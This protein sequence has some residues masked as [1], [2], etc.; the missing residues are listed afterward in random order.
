MN[1]FCCIRL[2]TGVKVIAVLTAVSKFWIIA[3]NCWQV[4]WLLFLLFF[5]FKVWALFSFSVRLLDTYT[6]DP[7][8]RGD[9][10]EEN[11][12]QLY[13]SSETSLEEEDDWEQKTD[14]EKCKNSFA[15]FNVKRFHSSDLLSLIVL[16]EVTHLIIMGYVILGSY[17]LVLSYI[18][19]TGASQVS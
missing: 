3:I 5:C 13:H 17:Y 7:D 1:T 9:D 12:R 16:A 18:L 4:M 10:S 15:I 6:L 19:Y 8:I 14:L 2:P 11:S